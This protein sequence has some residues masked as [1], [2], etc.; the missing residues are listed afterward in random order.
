MNG[1]LVTALTSAFLGSI[2][3]GLIFVRVFSGQDIRNQGSGN[4]GTVNVS[5]VLGFWPVGFLT[6]LFDTLKGVAAVILAS[7]A[8]E[9]LFQGWTFYP[10]EIWQPGGPLLQWFAGF[11]AVAGHCYT[12]WLRFR[13]GKGVATGFGAMILLSPWA[14]LAAILAFGI[15]FFSMRIGSLSSLVGLL[16]LVIAHAVLPGF[17]I[18]PHLIFGALLVFIILA[19]HEKNLDALLESRENR[20]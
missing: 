6:F 10:V 5:R 1:V 2:P 19:R 16:I 9:S 14:S 3:F 15:M 8:A 12:P 11:C 13:G 18:G 20:F 17:E 7:K 4:I